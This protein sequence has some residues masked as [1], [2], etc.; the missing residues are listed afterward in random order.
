MT[1]YLTSFDTFPLF[2]TVFV[3]FDFKVFGVWSGPLICDLHM[4]SVTFS[5]LEGS[6]LTSFLTLIDIFSLSRTVF[7]LID[8]KVFGVRP[9]PMTFGGDL[10]SNIFSAFG[11]PYT[12]SHL[13][14]IDNFSLFCTVFEI[15]DLEVFEVHF[16]PLTFGGQL[17]SKI[18]SPFWSTYTTSYKTSIDAFSLSRTVFETFDFKIFRVEP[19]PLNFA[20]YLGL[21]MLPAFES[22]YMTSY[23]T[24]SDTFSSSR[25][26][27]EIFDFKVFGVW[28]WPMTFVGCLRLKMFSA[29][30]S[31]WTISHLTSVDNFFFFRT[32]FEIFDF[33]VFG[34]WFWPLSFWSHLRSKIFS[35][36][37]S[38]YTTSYQTSVEA[39]SVTRTV[40]G[41]FDFKIF[42]VSPWRLTFAGYLRLNV[43]PTFESRY[44]TPHLTFFDTLSLSCTVFDIYGFKNFCGTTLTFDLQCLHEFSN[45]STNQ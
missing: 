9:W 1:H 43:F 29:F 26:V 33:E 36:F 19:W 17:R 39:F 15:F 30:G 8:F 45:I 27:F 4:S 31:P 40:F 34:V 37:E 44:V 12:T 20:G 2:R 35:L 7:E 23:P 38:S 32:V 28:P 18:F 21:N 22:T 11:S 10:G 3:I 41:I 24:P 25:T 6:Y 14:S 16:W 42:G 5:L 13:T